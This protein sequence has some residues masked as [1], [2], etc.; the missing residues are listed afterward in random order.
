MEME[1][2]DN[3]WRRVKVPNGSRDVKVWDTRTLG[4]FL[5]VF[6]SGKAV[7]GVRY[8]VNG[9]PRQM[10]LRDA[11][12][13]GSLALARREAE[14]RRVKARDDGEDPI[15]KRKAEREAAAR[16]RTVLD[17]AKDYIKAKR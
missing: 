8:H 2:R 5:R 14:N 9:T 15:A 16:A 6:A 17:V 1:L 3:S 12:P 10:S 11:T 13:K 7:Y 4:F